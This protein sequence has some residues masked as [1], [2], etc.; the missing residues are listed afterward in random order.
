MHL[1]VLFGMVRTHKA[2]RATMQRLFEGGGDHVSTEISNANIPGNA[3]VA[4]VT[5]KVLSLVLGQDFGLIDDRE[6]V[7]L[8]DAVT[9]MHKCSSGFNQF[10]AHVVSNYIYLS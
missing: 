1:V 3:A 5:S 9:E 10:S 4:T 7:L 2:K 6:N 8:K